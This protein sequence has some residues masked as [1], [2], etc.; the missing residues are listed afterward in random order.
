MCRKVHGAAFG[1]FLHADGRGF[2][3]LSGES[4][5]KNYRSSP[6]NMRAFCS[7][8]GSNLP[9]LENEGDHVIVPAGSLDGDPQVRPIV[10]IHTASKAPWFEITDSLPQFPEFPPDS[11]WIR[12]EKRCP[13]NV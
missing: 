4:M 1:S 13:E 8:C 10:H 9:V 12:Q 5:V 2:R 6:G 3:W 7:T 11:F